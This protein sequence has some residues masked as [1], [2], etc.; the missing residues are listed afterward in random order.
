[1]RQLLEG[2]SPRLSLRPF[3]CP[4]FTHPRTSSFF[5]AIATKTKEGHSASSFRNILLDFKIVVNT[6][7]KTQI[8]K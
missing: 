1:M 4:I 3:F 5:A 7:Q 2:R 8:S 6:G